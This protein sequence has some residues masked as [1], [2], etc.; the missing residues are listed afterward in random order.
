[1]DLAVHEACGLLI[2]MHI[3]SIR[4]LTGGRVL[5]RSEDGKEWTFEPEEGEPP[6]SGVERRSISH[7]WPLAQLL[8]TPLTGSQIPPPARGT[9][10]LVDKSVFEAAS[11]RR[12]IGYAD[13]DSAIRDENGQVEAYRWIIVR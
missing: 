10:L 11:G 2:S 6:M 1:M 13:P 7:E 3:T 5:L 9:L 12:D 4:N 8:K